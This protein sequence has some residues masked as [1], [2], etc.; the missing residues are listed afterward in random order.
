MRVAILSLNPFIPNPWTVNA[1]QL[2]DFSGGNTGN[3]AFQFAVT[4][5]IASEY[6]IFHPSTEPEVLRERADIIVM[7]LANQLGQHTDLANLATVLEKAQLP[8]IGIGLGAQATDQ[9]QDVTLTEGTERWVRTLAALAP[10]AGPNIG[11]RG[12][13]TRQQLEKIGLGDSAAVMGCPSNFIAPNP[14]FMESIQHKL[15]KPFSS[16]AV[17]AGIPFL[18]KLA[19]I[20]QDLADLV[21]ATHGVYIV[22]HGVQMVRLG[23]GDFDLMTDQELD[24]SRSYIAPHLPTEAFKIWCKTYARAY[25][26]VRQW[27]DELRRY[28]FAVGTRFHGAMLAVQ[29]GTPAGCISHDSRVLE[30]CQTMGI[31]VIESR[32]LVGGVTRSRLSDMFPFDGDAYAAKREALRK[33]YVRILEDGGLSISQRLV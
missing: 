11:V 27:M 13:Y 19:K 31:P 33:A 21:T 28:D 2:F 29:A 7:P 18:P 8:V 5:H 10:S 32:S 6:Q 22:Q 24:L 1:N 26:D 17:T 16:I 3:M 4:Q 15:G 23:R 30:M 14:N 20:E 9:E 25:S 12:E